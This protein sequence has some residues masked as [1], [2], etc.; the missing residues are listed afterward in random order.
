MI[1]CNASG[2]T[3]QEIEV[4]C[5]GSEHDLERGVASA[6]VG[7]DDFLYQK[8]EGHALRA[9]QAVRLGQALSRGAGITRGMR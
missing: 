4:Y 1:R 8:L 9:R 6:P 3:N 2:H 5:Q 7:C